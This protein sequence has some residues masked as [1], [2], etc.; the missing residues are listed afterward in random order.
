MI[1]VLIGLLLALFFSAAQA[2]IEV[3]RLSARVTDQ[4]GTLDSGQI[5]ALEARLAAFERIKGS[6]I[7]VLI[8]PSTQPE[9]IEQFGIRVAEAWKIGRKDA[10]DGVI[11]LVAKEDR[12][13][14]IEVGYGLE[15]ALPDAIAKRIIEEAIVPRFKA[16]DFY[17]G[18]SEGVERI[19]A[20]IEGEPLPEPPPQ[21]S[22]ISEGGNDAALA[23]V[24]PALFFGGMLR[25]WL[26]R[27]PGAGVAGLLAGALAWFVLGLV[28][29]A[30]MAGLLGFAIVMF[31][32]G[33]RGF[34]SVGRGGGVFRGGGGFGGGGGGFGGGGAS[35]RW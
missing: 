7:A 35:G 19:I 27:L 5:A 32:G 11:L 34:G 4:T 25:R 24:L 6:Q 18:I 3:P 22:A 8:I 10:D 1:R 21:T 13:L 28:M 31:G 15:G 29:P 9:T 23:A 26:G 14:R 33:R 16:N 20:V 2:E 17:G 12:A 30:V